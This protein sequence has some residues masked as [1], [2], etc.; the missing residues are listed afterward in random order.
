[1]YMNVRTYT[2]RLVRVDIKFGEVH[3]KCSFFSQGFKVICLAFL[4]FK[5]VESCNFL[6]ISKFN[7]KKFWPKKV[8]LFRGKC[9]ISFSFYM[10]YAGLH[11]RKIIIVVNNYL[12]FSFFIG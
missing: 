7:T 6:L 3:Y 10:D 1:M 8:Q 5:E 12:V 2:V 11:Q 4:Q 9:Y